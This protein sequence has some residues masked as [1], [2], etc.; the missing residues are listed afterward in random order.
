LVSSRKIG[1]L[2]LH[3]MDHGQGSSPPWTLVLGVAAVEDIE[4]PEFGRIGA[5]A[6]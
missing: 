3:F 6:C 1:G 4:P 2:S 5:A